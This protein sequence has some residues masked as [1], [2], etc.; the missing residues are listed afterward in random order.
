MGGIFW[1]IVL[2]INY[3]VEVQNFK[4]SKVSKL[5]K[6][7]MLKKKKERKKVTSLEC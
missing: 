5:K 6:S 1:F 3:L 4:S 7:E 2:H